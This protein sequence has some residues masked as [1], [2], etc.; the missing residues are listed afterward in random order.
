[1]WNPFG[2]EQRGPEV[3]ILARVPPLP[4]F[5]VLPNFC[6]W[7]RR[8]AWETPTN[9][10]NFSHVP[11]SRLTKYISHFSIL[12]WVILSKKILKASIWGLLT[13]ELIDVLLSVIASL[14]LQR[15]GFL[16][17]YEGW[18]LSGGLPVWHNNQQRHWLQPHGIPFEKTIYFLTAWE[19]SN[20]LWFADHS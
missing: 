12:G 6:W 8:H 19:H 20:T 11:P 3:W 7:Q 15:L 14:P 5:T 10:N 18:N 17:Y 16:V 1:M 13:L 4:T 9:L 2:D